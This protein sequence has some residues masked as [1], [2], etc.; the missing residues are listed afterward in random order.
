[1]RYTTLTSGDDIGF[2][3]GIWDMP[4]KKKETKKN[5]QKVSRKTKLQ[6]TTFSFLFT[7]LRMSSSR[8][9]QI[10]LQNT[11]RS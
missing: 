6:L 8:D 1:M 2:K 7:E 3:W 9:R 5:K 4:P 11:C 10:P